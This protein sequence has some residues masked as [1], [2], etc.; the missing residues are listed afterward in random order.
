MLLGEVLDHHEPAA[1]AL[2]EKSKKQLDAAQKLLRAIQAGNM[3]EVEKLRL[4]AEDR[5]EESRRAAGDVCPVEFDTAAY[6]A[7]DGE[8]FRELADAAEA[9]G[10]RLF[11]RD[12]LVF[13]YPVLLRSEPAE[14]TV[15]V[16]KT[17][18]T[19]IRPSVLAAHLKK[20]Q[21]KDARA[22]PERM[23]RMLA[24]AYP[25]V[26]A[27]SGA[28]LGSDV[29][30][31]DIYEVMTLGP[32][33]KK[34]YSLLDFARDI[35]MLDI[36]GIDSVGDQRLSF[37]ASTATRESKASTIRFVDRE[38]HEKVYSRVRFTTYNGAS[39]RAS[40]LELTP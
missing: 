15:R 16:D 33:G 23:L 32:D 6:L 22:K 39:P 27:R 13:C 1:A 31:I 34:E 2:V 29:R 30:L 9:A 37:A 20:V 25:Y 8:F 11:V 21:Q 4:A 19:S 12:G 10:V 14:G 35:Y 17:L 28:P 7:S 36:S 5:V 24:A 40:A 3:R 38:G 18:H 26:A